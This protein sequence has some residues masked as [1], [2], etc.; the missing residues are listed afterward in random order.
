MTTIEE[1]LLAVRQ[2]IHAAEIAAARPSD[3]VRLIAVSKTQPSSALAEAYRCGQRD[4]GENYVQEA[5][6]KQQDLLG[7]GIVWHFIGPI[8]SN[9]TRFIAGHFDWVHSVDRWKIAERLNE[10]RQVAQSPLNVTLQVNVS[11]ESTKGGVGLAELPDLVS[12]VLL[13]PNL[14][15]RGL[16]SI[17]APTDDFE[18][19]RAACRELRLA[20]QSLRLS[21]VDQLSM[22][23]SDDLEAAILEGAT[24]VRI[25]TAIFGRR[26]T[27]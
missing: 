13:L 24:M 6:V 19:Q 26:V 23:M 10:Q 3:S 22:G 9:K 16:M 1:R 17:P 8:Q 2:R 7:M 15:L 12:E 14:K 27:C 20:L 21:H 25:G 18:Q 11:G 4:F 5:L